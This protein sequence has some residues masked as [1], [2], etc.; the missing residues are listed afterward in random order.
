MPKVGQYVAE[1]NPCLQ[2]PL[3]GHAGSKQGKGRRIVASASLPLNCRRTVGLAPPSVTIGFRLRYNRPV[4][5]DTPV[6]QAD[7]PMHCFTDWRSV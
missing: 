4:C 5:I 2:M 6:G 7:G 3:N 1:V